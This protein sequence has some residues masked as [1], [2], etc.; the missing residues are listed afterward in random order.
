M[1][2]T[3]KAKNIHDGL[4][5]NIS[6][7]NVGKVP[8]V[9]V[10]RIGGFAQSKFWITEKE[11]SRMFRMKTFIQCVE[12]QEEIVVKEK[13]SMFTEPFVHEDIKMDIDE[14]KVAQAS[15]F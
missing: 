7:F 4:I 11:L 1:T 9:E 6:Y 13:K 2:R 12:V 10:E 3:V 14:K 5:R 8:M 15:L